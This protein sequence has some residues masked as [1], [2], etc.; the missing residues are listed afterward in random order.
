VIAAGLIL[1]SPNL[2]TFNRNNPKIQVAGQVRAALA[3]GP[4][5]Q[6]C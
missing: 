2:Q 5:S 1:G 4:V 3:A 6:I